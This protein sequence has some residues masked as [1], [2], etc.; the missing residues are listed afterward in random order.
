MH[1]TKA[2][3][4][5]RL[6]GLVLLAFVVLD[7]FLLGM[8]NF[9]IYDE[10]IYVPVA[11][12]MVSLRPVKVPATILGNPVSLGTEPN[13]TRY[14]PIQ[15]IGKDFTVEQPPLG[16]LIIAAFLYVFTPDRVIFFWARVPSVI[17]SAI[18]LVS[19]YGIGLVL[20]KDKR[21]ALLSMVFLNFDTLFWIH[22]RIALLDIYGLAFMLLGIFLYLRNHMRVSAVFFALSIL[23]KLTG[24][25]GFVGILIY[26]LVT[27]HDK[28]NIKSALTS[29]GIC[30]V[31]CVT[32]YTIYVQFWGMSQNP[33]TNF[34]LYLQ[35]ARG[36]DWTFSL[37]QGNTA[38]SQPWAWLFND[39]VVHY[40]QIFDPSTGLPLV[41][42]L[43]RLNP[44]LIFPTVPVFAYTGYEMIKKRSPVNTLPFILFMATW[45]P[46]FFLTILGSEQFIHHMVGVIPFIVLAIVYWLRTQNK[47]FLVGFSVFVF[48][49]WFWSYPYSYLWLFITG[50]P[51][52]LP[53]PNFFW[54]G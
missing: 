36:V 18:A 52:P 32:V 4:E 2:L 49:A 35:W 44:A 38:L 16:K 37:I 19:M 42:F 11:Y 22:S 53:I 45:L 46:W 3:R 13:L 5:H 34:L 43:G 40:A 6:A 20:F 14:Y 48:A 17:M 7:L 29:I 30:G 12:N 50:S 33:I 47:V 41:S 39:A 25:F 54:G 26:H 27:K 8:P 9:A 51:Y 23:S 10:L 31:V 24:V 21:Y 1:F 15:P 28:A